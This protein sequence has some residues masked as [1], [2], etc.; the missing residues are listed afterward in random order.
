MP[1]IHIFKAGPLIA[2]VRAIVAAGGSSELEAD[3]VATNLVEANLRG[4]DS[5]GVGMVPRYI[6]ALQEGGLIANEH[7]GIVLDGG[8][9]LTLD[10]LSLIHISEATRQ[11]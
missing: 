3:L 5:H 8:A 9:L 6:D 11:A 1:E 10:G 4:H 7:V 2:A